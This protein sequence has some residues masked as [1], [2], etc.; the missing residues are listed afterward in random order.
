MAI[1]NALS[2][3]GKNEG[4]SVQILFR[5]AQKNWFAPAKEY[6]EN[7]SK[8]GTKTKMVGAGIGQ[9]AMDVLKAP[10]ENC[11]I[12]RTHNF[13]YGHHGQ[14]HVGHGRKRQNH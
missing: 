12:Q 14:R 3:V 5:P 7:I 11:Q 2:A 4:A 10:F 6:I 13:R 9:F 8:G 1:L